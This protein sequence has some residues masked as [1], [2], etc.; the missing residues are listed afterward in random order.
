MDPLDANWKSI[1]VDYATIILVS[2]DLFI[3]L[4]CLVYWKYYIDLMSPL[5]NYIA[6]CIIRVFIRNA[7]PSDDIERAQE[8]NNDNNNNNNNG[9]R[10]NNNN[11]QPP[12]FCCF[13]SG[14]HPEVSEVPKNI[15][16]KEILQAPKT[17][18][19][20]NAV[21]ELD[22]IIVHA[23]KKDGKVNA[24]NEEICKHDM[25]QRYYYSNLNSFF[26]KNLG[27]M[28]GEYAN[29]GGLTYSL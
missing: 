8:H 10:T 18:K 12:S 11:S 23:P 5:Y 14:A 22:E 27:K 25:G 1:I 29:K 24:K 9:D 21:V 15:Q 28:C 3:M 19:Y 26:E 17:S 20:D 7:T 16:P 13:G 2:M 4:H 6:T